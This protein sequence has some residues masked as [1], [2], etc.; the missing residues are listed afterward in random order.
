MAWGAWV[1][2]GDHDVA[3][4]GSSKSTRGALWQTSGDVYYDPELVLEQPHLSADARTCGAAHAANGDN[5]GWWWRP[6]W[7]CPTLGRDPTTYTGIQVSSWASASHGF[8]LA[9]DYDVLC[10]QARWWLRPYSDAAWADRVAGVITSGATATAQVTGWLPARPSGASST[11]RFEVTVN[12]VECAFGDGIE[13]ESTIGPFDV[14]GIIDQA[15]GD[16]FADAWLSPH[17]GRMYDWSASYGAGGAVTSGSAT[18]GVDDL[19]RGLWV[20]ALHGSTWYLTDLGYDPEFENGPGTPWG[21]Q[22]SPTL[23]GSM[24]VAARVSWWYPGEAVV[25]VPLRQIQ[26]DDGLVAGGAPRQSASRTSR[27]RSLRQMGYW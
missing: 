18:A 21:G 19:S 20:R 25:D 24:S 23:V 6:G 3:L 9:W 2:L 1:D 27:Q 13:Y 26:R 22:V 17:A 10:R 8:M 4:P 7:A 5:G 11:W 12:A 14:V 16:V 15:P